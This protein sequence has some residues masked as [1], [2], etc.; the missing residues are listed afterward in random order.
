MFSKPNKQVTVPALERADRIVRTLLASPWPLGVSELARAVDLSKSSVHALI[1]SLIELG[2]L[3]KSPEDARGV[4]PARRLLD[5]WR[6][7][8]LESPF[9]QA[10]KPLLGVFSERHGLT[11]LAGVF[12]QA[13]V[14]I[15]E[16]VLAPGFSI[17]AYPG[18]LVPSWAGALGKVLLAAYPPGRAR[19]LAGAMAAH[20][21][22]SPAAYLAE[23]EA[24]RET[25]VAVDREEYIP[26][27]RALAAAIP[28]GRPIEPLR[29]VWA[30]GLAPSLTDA[31]MKT[32]AEEIRSLAEE[33]GRRTSDITDRE[34]DARGQA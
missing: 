23:V 2:L 21:P 17:S 29:A 9:R 22:L 11:A 7:V 15:V 31:R 4:R 26:G 18:Q 1:H 34:D 12:L 13:R 32:A 5:L 3:E 28:N 33:I 19:A 24:A 25:G 6:Q 16:A 8:M 27:V 10:A 14:L 20:S 30:V